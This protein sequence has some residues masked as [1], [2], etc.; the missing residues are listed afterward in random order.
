MGDHR[1]TRSDSVRPRS[2]CPAQLRT[3]RAWLAGQLED[4]RLMVDNS[5]QGFGGG[6]G[7]NPNPGQQ[8]WPQQQSPYGPP[9]GY[10]PPQGYG[11]PPGYGPPA[12][13]GQPN[14]PPPGYPQY[15]SPG[16]YRPPRPKPNFSDIPVRDY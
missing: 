11:P 12:G 13:Y 3:K 9:P 16:Q 4:V 1:S 10:G 2:F 7:P 14:Y 8:G 15:Q 6:S 5:N